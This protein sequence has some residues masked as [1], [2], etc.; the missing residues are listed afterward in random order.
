LE[1]SSNINLHENPARGSP[2]VRCE[3]TDK[4]KDMTK[5]IVFYTNVPKKI[6]QPD[7][8]VLNLNEIN[9]T[10]HFQMDQPTRRSNLSSLLLVV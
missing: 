5:L 1:K 9:V 2:V 3:H 10:L 6:F 4:Q 8:F 7:L